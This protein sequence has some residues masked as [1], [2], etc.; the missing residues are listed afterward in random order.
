M[1]GAPSALQDLRPLPYAGFDNA[2]DLLELEGETYFWCGGGIGDWR[3]PIGCRVALIRGS[4]L[5][6]L[7]PLRPPAELHPPHQ[8]HLHSPAHPRRLYRT[9]LNFEASLGCFIANGTAW[10]PPAGWELYALLNLTEPASNTEGAPAGP[11]PGTVVLPFAAVL[12]NREEE[13]LVVAVRG[14]QTGAEWAIDFSYNQT[15]EV[16]A[17]GNKPVHYGFATVFQQLWP[18]VE[19]ALADLVA[20]A[21]PAATQAS[22]VG[23]AAWVVQTSCVRQ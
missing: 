21:S 20:G 18:G 4:A 23:S 22:M 17:L 19:A 13:Q 7:R 12:L 11:A 8:P 15:A 14:T 2:T 6:L 10:E 5:S 1:P 16:A 9:L 3:L